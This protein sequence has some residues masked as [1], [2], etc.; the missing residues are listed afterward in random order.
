MAL[1]VAAAPGRAESPPPA[2]ERV[3]VRAPRLVPSFEAPLDPVAFGS[4]IGTEDAP[5]WVTS[6]ADVLEDAVGVRVRRFG[7][8]GEFSSVSVRGFSA[9]QVQVYLDGVPITRA[10]DETVD[11]AELPLD[12]IERV[13]VYRGTTSLDFA[14][15]SPGGVINIV[16]RRPTGKPMLAASLGYG[17]FGTRKATLAAGG[18]AGGWEYLAFGHYL[19]SENDFRFDSDSGTPTTPGDDR[20]LE[21]INADFNGGGLT[22]RLRRDVND[23]FHLLLTTDTFAK[24]QGLPGRDPVQAAGNRRGVLRQLVSLD[25]VLDTDVGLPAETR[26][27]TYFVYRHERVRVPGCLAPV[28]PACGPVTGPR[29][30]LTDSFSTGGQLVTRLLLASWIEPRAL[31]AVGYETFD[32]RDQTRVSQT[33]AAGRAPTRSRLRTTLGADV[34]IRAWGDRIS[35]VPAIRWERF[36]DQFPRDSRIDP[37]LDVGAS[38]TTTH[39]VLAPRVGVRVEP[40][41]GLTLLGN[42]GRWERVPNLLELFGVSG[43]VVGRPDLKP[44]R[45]RSWDV[46]AR[47]RLPWGGLDDA[48]VEYA[49]YDSRIDDAI[50][51]LPSSVSVFRP[52]NVGASRLQGHEVSAAV[53]RGPLGLSGNYTH[54]DAR[55]LGADLAVYRGNQLPGRAADQAYG[56]LDVAWPAP[57][58]LPFGAGTAFYDV[59]WVGPTFL[60]RANTDRVGAR[61]LHGVGVEITLPRR[62]RLGLEVRNL[63]DDQT[64][65][66]ADF[67]LPGRTMFVTLSYGFGD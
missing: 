60:D 55:D 35:V 1:V 40:V 46:G 65:D 50:V 21:R 8:L 12:A 59:S 5:R 13:E 22:T 48:W 23:D 11:L 33:T 56:R 14:Q 6:L 37:A 9:G 53:R 32:Q 29:D 54:L 41:E 16:P 42:V 27:S 67:P 20:R 57:G 39:D 52:D 25:G 3:V 62:L 7:G 15:S 66:V 38:G 45:A 26:G 34:E 63:T 44:E 51:L 49:Y 18:E 36:R 30:T 64:R 24:E 17:S 31:A 28:D 10:D 4:T 43:T 47:W 19:G 61:L 58:G 2:P